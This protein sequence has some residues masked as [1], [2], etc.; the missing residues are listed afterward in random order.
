MKI[1]VVTCLAQTNPQHVSTSES[2]GLTNMIKSETN[3]DVT[4]CNTY[5]FDKSQHYD[6]VIISGLCDF[7]NMFGGIVT[8]HL[9]QLCEL[10]TYLKSCPDTKVY[11]AMSDNRYIINTSF[12]DRVKNGKL[13]LPRGTVDDIDFDGLKINIL[14]Q[15]RNVEMSREIQKYDNIGDVIYFPIS[16]FPFY[17]DYYRGL[18]QLDKDVDLVYYGTVRPSRIKKVQKYYDNP[19]C[20]SYM[21]GRGCDGYECKNTFCNPQ[22]ILHMNMMPELM[23]CKYTVLVGDKE[24]EKLL[25]IPARVYE[26]NV[27][28]IISFFDND[29]DPCHQF[30]EGIDYFYVDS[31]EELISKIKELNA[32]ESKRQ[33]IYNMQTEILHRPF[34]FDVF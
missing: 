9:Y 16:R 12:I 10:L 19:D 4:F 3:H 22:D 28:E 25:N 5:T 27:A 8:D 33:E 34:D 18:F 14:T 29:Y 1:N 30:M 7:Q 20:I 13:K 26:A 15:F 17:I 23:R 2:K 31:Q 21:F 6:V 32:N 24:Y 11:H